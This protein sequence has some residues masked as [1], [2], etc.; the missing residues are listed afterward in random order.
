MLLRTREGARACADQFTAMGGGRCWRLACQG[1]E[2][3]LCS[4]TATSRCG[5]ASAAL[6][7]ALSTAA[8][9]APCGSSSSCTRRGSAG[10]ASPPPHWPPPL[11]LGT[12]F[13]GTWRRQGG[14]EGGREGGTAGAEGHTQA[15]Q[16]LHTA[17]R[18]GWQRQAWGWGHQ[19]GWDHRGAASHAASS[20]HQLARRGA[21]PPPRRSATHFGQK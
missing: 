3:S 10:S 2:A 7:P 20:T 4:A 19:A 17:P 14:R 6:P 13:R 21:A 12:G 8:A 11:P 5:G 9:P 18:C 15:P 1:S 16:S